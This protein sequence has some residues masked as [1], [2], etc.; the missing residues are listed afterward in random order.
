MSPWEGPLRIEPGFSRRLGLYL[1]LSH[2]LGMSALMA[3]PLTLPWR[4]ALGLLVVISLVHGLRTQVLR[5]GAFA[6]RAAELDPDGGWWLY[7]AKGA[8]Q[9]ASLRRSSFVRPRLTV[10]NFSVGRFGR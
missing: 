6:L 10:L 8:I 9:S 2:G 3:M 1:V 5:S 4:L 7:T